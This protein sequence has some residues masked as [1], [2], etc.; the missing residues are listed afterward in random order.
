MAITYHILIVDD[1]EAD[2][3]AIRRALH[4]LGEGFVV[5]ER[6]DGKA[7]LQALR[8]GYF[9]C[10]L[11]DYPLPDMRGM[12]FLHAARDAQV[13]TPIIVLSW[14]GDEL[15]VADAFKA[16][17]ADYLPKAYV[18]SE[19]FVKTI[20]AALFRPRCAVPRGAADVIGE[21]FSR[22]TKREQE[23]LSMVLKGHSS[24]YI[25]HELGISCRTVE[26]HRSRIMEKTGCKT[27]AELIRSAMGIFGD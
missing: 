9:D 8:D 23:V 19:R 15:L 14:E 1:E 18:D 17:A 12:A 4:S 20:N 25:G 22:L 16:G 11:V 7:G 3:A 26:S 21:R 10:A 6:A 2:R 27:F 5:E 24:K 13:V